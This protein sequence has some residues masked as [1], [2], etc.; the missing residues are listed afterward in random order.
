MFVRIATPP[1]H[2]AILPTITAKVYGEK[3]SLFLFFHS[4]CG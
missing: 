1:F 3:F 4:N 2:A